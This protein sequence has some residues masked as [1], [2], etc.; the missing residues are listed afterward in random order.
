M[1]VEVRSYRIKPGRREE[2]I[3]FF[4]TCSIPAPGYVCDGPKQ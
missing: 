1:I 4:E 2:F 3:K